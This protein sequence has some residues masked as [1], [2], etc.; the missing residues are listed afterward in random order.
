M[1]DAPGDGG[2]SC[3]LASMCW[4]VDPQ[5]HEGECFLRCTGSP[6]EPV[7]PDGTTCVISNE[8]AFILC[9]PTCHPLMQDCPEGEA[10]LAAG[11]GFGRFACV[12]EYSG[13]EGQA[14][15]SCDYANSCDPG[16]LCA[17][18]E[19]A[20]ECD[21]NANG[22]CLPFCDTGQPGCP[23]AMQECLP[24]FDAGQPRQGT[25]RSECADCLCDMSLGTSISSRLACTGSTCLEKSPTAVAGWGRSARAHGSRDM[26]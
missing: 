16:L 4:D 15:D 6:E 5:T 25:S 12:A 22:C 9:L 2:D 18:P 17:G 23:G 14:F 1:E 11:E 8:G 3:D 24:W 21:P 20:V 26:S 10:C 19:A 7:C 13:D